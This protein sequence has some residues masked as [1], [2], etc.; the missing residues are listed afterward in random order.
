MSQGIYRGKD[1]VVHFTGPTAEDALIV[2]T[3]LSEFLKG[4]RPRLCEYTEETLPPKLA[5]KNAKMLIGLLQGE[6]D[7]LSFN[8]EHVAS[9]CKTGQTPHLSTHRREQRAERG[10]KGRAK[11]AERAKEERAENREM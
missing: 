8:C 4:G 7:L 5:S 3:S 11:R 2:Q 1:R 10:G 6:Y 9:W